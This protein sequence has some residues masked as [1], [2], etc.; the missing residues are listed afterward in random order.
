MSQLYISIF[1][2][3]IK[4]VIEKTNYTCKFSNTLL[5]N[6]VENTWNIIMHIN[7]GLLVK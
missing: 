5:F 4:N 1:S 6:D 3:L 7:M 2:T